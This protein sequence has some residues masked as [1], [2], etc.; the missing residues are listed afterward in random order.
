MPSRTL[1]GR[2]S[3]IHDFTYQHIIPTV[4]QNKNSCPVLIW[5]C[6]LAFIAQWYFDPFEMG[7]LFR[8][9]VT[10]LFHL[11]DIIFQKLCKNRTYICFDREYRPYGNTKTFSDDTGWGLYAWGTYGRA[12]LQRYGALSWRLRN[13]HMHRYCDSMWSSNDDTHHHKN[14][15]MASIIPSPSICLLLPQNTKITDWE[16]P[17]WGEQHFSF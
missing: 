10:I 1:W 7:L 9:A 13:R 3:Y 11:Q 17:F 8:L 4:L 14:T 15:I 16:L 5:L 12:Q 2:Q 6:F